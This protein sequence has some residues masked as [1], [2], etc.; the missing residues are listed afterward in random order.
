MWGGGKCE[1]VGTIFICTYY[2]TITS[3]S[4]CTFQCTLSQI[5]GKILL[6]LV[7]ENIYGTDYNI[8]TF[9]CVG[10]VQVIQKLMSITA[11]YYYNF[12]NV[13]VD[14]MI[15]METMTPQTPEMRPGSN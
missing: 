14:Q 6:C 2:N 15:H 10:V 13:D 4:A 9:C 12:I 1:N 5:M 7:T 3:K 11:D 8:I